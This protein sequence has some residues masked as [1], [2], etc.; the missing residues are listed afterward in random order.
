MQRQNRGFG[1]ETAWGEKRVSPLRSSQ[2]A[3]TAP[4]E[5]TDLGWERGKTKANRD[6]TTNKRTGKSNS[7]GNRRENSQLGIC[8]GCVEGQTEHGEL[9]GLGGGEAY[10][11]VG[12]AAVDVELGGGGSVALDEEGL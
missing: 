6:R 7:N 9:G 1:A 4:V 10:E 11:E 8:R 3:R 5:M 12:Y 2:S